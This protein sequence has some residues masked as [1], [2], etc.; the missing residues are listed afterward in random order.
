ML[1]CAVAVAVVVAVVVVAVVVIVIATCY[2]CWMLFVGCVGFVCC[3]LSRP[4]HFV[5]F[6]APPHS[7]VSYVVLVLF[8]MWLLLLVVVSF[9]EQANMLNCDWS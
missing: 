8:V 5:L 7:L 1:F 6:V 9:V 3:L 2:D 4:L